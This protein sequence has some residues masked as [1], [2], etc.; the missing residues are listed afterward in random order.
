LNIDL[1]PKDIID[2]DFDYADNMEY[3]M[4]QLQVLSVDEHLKENTELGKL[5]KKLFIGSNFLERNIRYENEDPSVYIG[6]LRE[7]NI[8]SILD[9]RYSKSKKYDRG[10]FSSYYN[11]TDD[12]LSSLP[13]TGEMVH[14]I[15][16][17]LYKNLG[18]HYNLKIYTWENEL[19]EIL[20]EIRIL[21]T[22]TNKILK[23]TE[24][25]TGISQVL[26]IVS[27]SI[28]ASYQ[29]ICIEQPE[30]HL[31]PK[32]QAD[33][34]DIILTGSNKIKLEI[35]HPLAQTGNNTFLIETHSE[36][37][38]L[39]IMK[40]IRQTTHGGLPDDIPPIT[41]DD[42]AVLYVNPTENECSEILE[43]RL[44]EDGEFI[45][46]WPDGFFEEGYRERFF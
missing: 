38:L 13:F 8:H 46:P 44:D 19:G 20:K 36:H 42:V 31:H 25:G 5:L 18:L 14:D 45:D 39:R 33:L 35:D 15:N 6:P 17:Y 21:D 40:R 11:S 37:L 22:K 24:I 27:A 10:L 9:K 26:P 4:L 29:K 12:I 1:I 34:A 30:L 41:P 28:L 43:L 3:Y 16:K 2:I 23:S 7:R 32:M